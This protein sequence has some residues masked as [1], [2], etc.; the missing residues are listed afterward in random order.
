MASSLRYID[1]STASDRMPDRFNE[2]WRAGRPHV[3]AK[4]V[5][6]RLAAEQ[7]CGTVFTDAPESCQVALDESDK[8]LFSSMLSNGS[9]A[10]IS[11]QL[12]HFGQGVKL[13]ISDKQSQIINIRYEADTLFTPVTRIHLTAGASAHIIEEHYSSNSA[14]LFCLRSITLE[15]GAS[16]IIELRENGSGDSYCFNISDIVVDEATLTHFTEHKQ[17]A[18]AREETGVRLTSKAFEGDKNEVKLLSANY[19]TGT[20]VLDQRTNQDHMNGYTASDLLYKNVIDG[21]AAAIF[22]G[23]I[24]V[25]ENA[26]YSDAYLNNF[27]LM[28]SKDALI[29]SMPGLEILADQV[30]CSHGSASGPLN[31]EELFYLCSRGIPK[32]EAQKLV[33]EGYLDDVRKRIP[34]ND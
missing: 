31:E 2:M 20:Q 29:H 21:K 10:L 28:L 19:L 33:A 30:R 22:D 23:N 24:M 14:L 15:K 18:W 3:Y 25:A 32:Y 34:A 17:H 9:Q 5:A 6:E 4:Q 7:S 13:V 11:E 8:E 26:H 16:L 27:N 1:R 12:K